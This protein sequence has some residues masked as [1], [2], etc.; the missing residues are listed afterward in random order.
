MENQRWWG[1]SIRSLEIWR[2]TGIVICW[3]VMW[4]N[5][6][7]QVMSYS[8]REQ[9]GLC[10]SLSQREK[11]NLTQ[12]Q[13]RDSLGLTWFKRGEIMDEIQFNFSPSFSCTLSARSAWIQEHRWSCKEK[14]WI[15]RLQEQVRW[16]PRE[17]HWEKENRWPRWFLW[18]K[19]R[20][21]C[22][23]DF[24]VVSKWS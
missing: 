24:S 15:Y 11:L 23:P 12:T 6:E 2:F 3:T 21:T 10:W 4:R 1:S 19:Q 16:Q 9:R 17:T 8:Q 14:D 7:Q 5:K 13:S 22:F 20:G 18:E